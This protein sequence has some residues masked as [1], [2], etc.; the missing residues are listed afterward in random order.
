MTV[1]L[2]VPSGFV[3]ALIA[4]ATSTMLKGSAFSR[5]RRA[6]E[7]PVLISPIALGEE[8]DLGGCLSEFRS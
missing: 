7:H 8:A 6:K 2:R 3:I 4:V 5:A 1:E